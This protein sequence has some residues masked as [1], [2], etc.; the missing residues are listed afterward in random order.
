MKNIVLENDI[1]QLRPIELT[2]IDA[3]T[4]AANDARIWEHMSV[5]LLDRTSV[6]N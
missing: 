2:D 5:T 1:V 6:E 4:V 3:I